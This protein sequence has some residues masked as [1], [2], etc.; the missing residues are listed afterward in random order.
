MNESDRLYLKMIFSEYFG[1]SE[2]VETVLD[3]IVAYL[4]LPEDQR[5]RKVSASVS[6]LDER[7]S[8]ELARLEAELAKLLKMK[9]EIDRA[10]SAD[11]GV[12]VRSR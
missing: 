9:A 8:A 5:R 2:F 3:Q 4:N 12:I 10:R 11:D 7:I 1:S 6:T